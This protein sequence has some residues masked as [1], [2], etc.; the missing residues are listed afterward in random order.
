VSAVTATVKLPSIPSSTFHGSLEDSNESIDY[1]GERV[2]DT[3]ESKSQTYNV[4]TNDSVLQHTD[5]KSQES[6]VELEPS[7]RL[8]I[9][10]SAMCPNLVVVE[11][12]GFCNASE[13]AFSTCVYPGTTDQT[14]HIT[15][16]TINADV[17][18]GYEQI[19]VAS[20]QRSLQH[21]L[22]RDDHSQAVY[23]YKLNTGAHETASVLKIRKIFRRE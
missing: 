3:T 8:L 2:R 17:D 21:I 1:H 19:L 13:K 23:V 4:V 15:L 20:E 11:L 22:R 5:T 14:G 16:Q 9:L 6:Q 12:P 10:R 7:S 18:K